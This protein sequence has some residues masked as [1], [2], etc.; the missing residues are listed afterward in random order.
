ML[1]GMLLLARTLETA[2]ALGG[3]CGGS[4]AGGAWPSTASVGTLEDA[5]CA[6]PTAAAPP[7]P[8]V[9]RARGFMNHSAGGGEQRTPSALARDCGARDEREEGGNRQR[10]R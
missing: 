5:A 6:S 7:W 2:G 4:A 10:R 8:A 9:L 1:E 3:G